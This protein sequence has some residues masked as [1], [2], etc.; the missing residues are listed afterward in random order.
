MP[1]AAHG[2]IGPIGKVVAKRAAAEG[3]SRRDFFTKVA[4]SLESEAQ[5]ERFLREA[6][7][8]EA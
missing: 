8:V 2:Y 4:Q 5:R 3:V 1:P 6:G 7:F